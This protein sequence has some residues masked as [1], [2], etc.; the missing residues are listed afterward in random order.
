MNNLVSAIYYHPEAYPPTL[1]A[2]TEL[3]RV[4]DKIAIVHRPHLIGEWEYP[5]NVRAI[6]SGKYISSRDQEKTGRVGKALFF[7]R[8]ISDLMLQCI[9]LRPSVIL[10]YDAHALFAYTLIRPFI[11]KHRLWYHN[12]DVS[13]KERES[14]YSIGWFACDVEKKTFRKMDLFTLPTP[15]RLRFFPL[16]KLKGKC[17]IVPNY[18]S[19]K[20]F[21]QFRSNNPS[22]QFFNLIF[23]GRIGEGHGLEEITELLGREIDGK[24]IRLVLKGYCDPKFKDHLVT[25]AGSERGPYLEFVG[26]TPYADVPKTASLCHV[27]IAIFAKTDVMNLTLGTASNKV[28]EYAALGLPVLYLE[29]SP[30]GDVLSKYYWAVGTTLH[31]KDIFEKLLYISKHQESLRKAALE[32]F[33][34]SL[35]FEI[36]FSPVLE[37]LDSV[38]YQ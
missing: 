28:Y 24:R 25:I 38:N 36:A 33:D 15:E 1:N 21:T 13:E 34:N 29:K 31:P 2:V 23:Q 32:D 5:G 27:G 9:R 20:F 35:N 37:Y 4:F 11:P 18:P 7:L 22:D 30:T 10:V 8:F 17:I 26:F 3:S 19:R 16:N 6:P 14:K 12:H